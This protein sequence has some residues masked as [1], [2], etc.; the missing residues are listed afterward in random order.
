VPERKDF[1]DRQLEAILERLGYRRAF[2]Y[3]KYRTIYSVTLDDEH[4]L[5]AMFDE[6]PI[7]NFLE[8]EGDSA[9][10][11]DVAQ[12]LGYPKSA[13]I[14]E[15]YVEMQVARCASKGEPLTDMV[16]PADE[17]KAPRAKPKK[18]ARPEKKKK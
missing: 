16:F 13:F 14:S 2:R 17:S 6:T 18:A 4:A 3:Q 12:R 15:S 1:S 7:G 8:L 10:I 5:L 9:V 11:E